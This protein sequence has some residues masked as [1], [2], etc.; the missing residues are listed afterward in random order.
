M[1]LGKVGNCGVGC[2]RRRETAHR[3]WNYMSEEALSGIKI[4]HYGKNADL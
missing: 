4:M 2:S 1:L 3:V